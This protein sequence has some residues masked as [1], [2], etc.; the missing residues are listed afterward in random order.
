MLK[1]NIR[2][3][4]ANKLSM[5]GLVLE[6][7]IGNTSVPLEIALMARKD[8]NEMCSLFDKEIDTVNIKGAVK[9]KLKSFDSLLEIVI[10][11]KLVS[12]ELAKKAEK[13]ISEIMAWLDKR[14]YKT[15]A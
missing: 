4:S 8:I 11:G 5:F 3:P 2:E 9:Q 13:D 7:I 12:I 1:S 6:R 15:R 14:E 10:A